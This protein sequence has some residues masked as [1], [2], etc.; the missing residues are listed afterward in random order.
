MAPLGGKIESVSVE[1]GT[2]VSKG[3][4]L[5]VMTAM[6]MENTII[7]PCSGIVKDINVQEGDNVDIDYRLFDIEPN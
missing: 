1:E 4:V 7:A 2:V 3:D 5:A 6:K